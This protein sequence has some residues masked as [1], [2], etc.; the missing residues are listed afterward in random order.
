MSLFG[1]IPVMISPMLPACLC[2]TYTLQGHKRSIDKVEL[3]IAHKFMCN[4]FYIGAPT[5][6]NSKCE[7]EPHLVAT[8]NP[9]QGN[10]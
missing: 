9:F 2:L 10:G 1:D 6:S 4:E 5:S 7:W 3:Q 8:S